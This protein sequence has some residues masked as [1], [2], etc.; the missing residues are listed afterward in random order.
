MEKEL[1]DR[2]IKKNNNKKPALHVCL[3]KSKRRAFAK[4]KFDHVIPSCLFSFP[5]IMSHSIAIDNHPC[6]VY[7]SLRDPRVLNTVTRPG[8]EANVL[9]VR[10][11]IHVTPLK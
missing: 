2:E 3:T 1:N 5:K 8:P 7:G 4:L 6:F 11:L 9:T 10:G